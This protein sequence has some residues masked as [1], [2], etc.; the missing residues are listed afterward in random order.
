MLLRFMKHERGSI[1][2]IAAGS[3]FAMV[4]FSAVC[5]DGGHL[6][7]TQGRLQIAADAAALAAAQF[8]GGSQSQGVVGA[9]ELAQLNMP[10]ARYG[11]VLTDGDIVYGNWSATTR[12]FTP[13]GSPANAVEVTT[14]YQ[15]PT[16]FAAIFGVSN[17]SLQTTAIARFTSQATP[18]VLAL[19]P[20]ASSAIRLDSNAEI[21]SPGCRVHSNSTSSSA[22]D[23]LSNSMITASETSVVGGAAGGNSHYNPAPKTGQEA[24]AD[25]L[26]DVA[27]PTVGSCNYNNRTIR[28]RTITISPGVY[29]GGLFIDGTSRVTFNPGVYVMKNGSFRV[30]ANSQATG[31][32]VSFYLTGSNAVIDFDSNTS[33]NLVA[34]STGAMAGILFFEDRSV[35]LLRTHSM[36]SNAIGR[37][38][39]TIYLSRGILSMDSNSI[40]GANSAFTNIVARQLSLNSNA[41]FQINVNYGATTVPNLLMRRRGSLVR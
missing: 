33:I 38:E 25:P 18:C 13:N 20:S 11:D 8:A 9:N 23:A 36:D 32:G 28:D 27:P 10:S 5:V 35:P 22:I 14:R 26:A 2:T 4:A 40:I 16:F 34:P 15:A 1:A 37:L 24:S 21:R 3:I 30:Y 31:T 39:G 29:C 6:Y 19:D 12:T 7:M 17:I 41:D